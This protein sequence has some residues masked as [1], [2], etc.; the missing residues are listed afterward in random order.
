V[1]SASEVALVGGGGTD[2]G[3]G[4][5][6]AYGLRP[7]PAVCVVLTD[8]YTPWPEMAPKGMRVVSGLLGAGAPAAPDWVRSVRVTDA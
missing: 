3:A 2:M 8:G 6:A 4:I 1:T 5:Q 7:R